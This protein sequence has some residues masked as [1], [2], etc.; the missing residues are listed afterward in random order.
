MLSRSLQVF[1]G[2]SA[3]VIILAQLDLVLEERKPF[4]NQS[5]IECRIESGFN[6]RHGEQP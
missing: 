5:P 1:L 4:A 3:D 2:V 6:L